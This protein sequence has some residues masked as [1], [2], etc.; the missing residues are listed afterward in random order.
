M[1]QIQTETN[2]VSQFLAFIIV[3][4]NIFVFTIVFIAVIVSVQYSNQLLNLKAVLLG[5]HEIFS[6]NAYIIRSDQAFQL[7]E[8]LTIATGLLDIQGYRVG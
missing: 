3:I 2:L 5:D 6:Y 8:Q 7:L 1:S 4:L